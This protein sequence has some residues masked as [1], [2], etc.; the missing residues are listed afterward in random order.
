[1]SSNLKA[2]LFWAAAWRGGRQEA[3]T[4]FIHVLQKKKDKGRTH[5]HVAECESTASASHKTLHSGQGCS[6]VSILNNCEFGA[7]WRNIAIKLNEEITNS[8]VRGAIQCLQGTSLKFASHVADGNIEINCCCCHSIIIIISVCYN[9][10]IPGFELQKGANSPS[11]EPLTGKN[12]PIF[13][14]SKSF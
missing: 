10:T 14:T 13:K 2:Y 11:S 1:M 12:S 5:G 6:N 8:L 7:R 4:I 3:A 9:L